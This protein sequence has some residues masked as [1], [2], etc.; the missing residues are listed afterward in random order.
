MFWSFQVWKR[1]DDVVPLLQI[2]TA[3]DAGMIFDREVVSVLE[4]WGR[5][6]FAV[7]SSG[8]YLHYR[9]RNLRYEAKQLGDHG[10]CYA[11][12]RPR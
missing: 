4:S 8:I 6:V 3:I 2:A 12:I 9:M 7:V 1:D 11:G 10:G 5:Y